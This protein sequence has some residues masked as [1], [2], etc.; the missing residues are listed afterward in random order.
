MPWAT[1]G[2]VG[3]GVAIAAGV[4]ILA[5]GALRPVPAETHFVSGGI[6]RQ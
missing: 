4:V 5:S 3:T 6:K 1:W 2:L